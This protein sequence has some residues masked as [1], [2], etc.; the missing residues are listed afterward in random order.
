VIFG[1]AAVG[2]LAGLIHA[3]FGGVRLESDGIEQFGPFGRNRLERTSIAGFREISVVPQ[4]GWALISIAPKEARNRSILVRG[5]VSLDP[6]VARWLGGYPN[7]DF[8]SPLGA[9]DGRPAPRLSYRAA[10]RLSQV[11]NTAGFALGGWAFFG[12]GPQDV[13]DITCAAA[14]LVAVLCAW[15]SRGAVGLGG[16]FGGRPTLFFLMVLPAIGLF[17]PQ[18]GDVLL[19]GDD[20]WL[21]ALLGGAMFVAVG[22]AAFPDIRPHPRGWIATGLFGAAYAFGLF[23]ALDVDLDHR[24]PQVFAARVLDGQSWSGRSSGYELTL[25]AW[26]PLRAPNKVSVEGWLYRQVAVGDA[27]C[28]TLHPGALGAAWFTVDLCP[29]Q[30]RPKP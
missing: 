28:V 16:Q 15:W 23:H 21:P 9:E 18:A 10:R 3:L 11:L 26:G 4:I 5:G 22:L 14:P 7:L 1:G 25:A 20:S 19:D 17:H 8:E 30:P 24:S 29:S 13:A 2:C 27:V 6:I 12:P